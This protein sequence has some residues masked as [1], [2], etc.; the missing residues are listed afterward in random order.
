MFHATFFNR[1]KAEHNE[2]PGT[3]F[4]ARSVFEAPP[5]DVRSDPP[6]DPPEDPEAGSSETPDERNITVHLV[7][8]DELPDINVWHIPVQDDIEEG[9]NIEYIRLF[10]EEEMTIEYDRGWQL[11]FFYNPG[12][13]VI[14]PDTYI[15]EPN[16]VLYVRINTTLVVTV[17][18]FP[19]PL[20]NDPTRCVIMFEDFS[21]DNMPN[22][23]LAKQ[24]L[25]NRDIFSRWAP[26]EMELRA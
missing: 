16:D 18:H 10:F 9:I 23:G 6:E 11:E 13:V 25:R 4:S 21:E 2:G 15:L 20:A 24:N 12:N 7:P 17:E 19:H 8:G 5:E 3:P 26:A 1:E 22:I 14:L